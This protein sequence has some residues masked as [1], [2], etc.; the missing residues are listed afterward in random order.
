MVSP[1]LRHAVPLP[2]PV[3]TTRLRQVLAIEIFTVLL[4][5]ALPALLLPPSWLA[6]FGTSASGTEEL[7]FVRLWG[8][9]IFAILV[10]QVLAWRAPARHPGTLLVAVV[11]HGLGATVI[12]SA[13]A[14]GAFAGWSIATAAYAWSSALAMAGLAIALGMTGLPLLRRLAE[15]PRPGSVKVM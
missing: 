14:G 4:A 7:L 12:V 13:G 3:D 2:P 15:R 5:W 8:A 1:R 10:G 9:T 6:A 11:A